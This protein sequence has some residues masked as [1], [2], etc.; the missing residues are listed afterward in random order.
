MLV[1]TGMREVPAAHAATTLHGAWQ[2]PAA[3]IL[4][5]PKFHDEALR[6]TSMERLQRAT[7]ARAYALPGRSGPVQIAGIVLSRVADV[8]RK[9]TADIARELLHDRKTF[10]GI[11]RTVFRVPLSLCPSDR[12]DAGLKRP[13]FCPDRIVIGKF[14]LF[15]RHAWIYGSRR[16]NFSGLTRERPARIQGDTRNRSRC[17]ASLIQSGG[18][19]FGPV[20]TPAAGRRRPAVRARPT[21][22]IAR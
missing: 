17:L 2:F 1:F 10:G 12:A 20:G 14:G 7:P 6:R 22:R 5:R 21:T 16:T 18:R 11:R 3:R 9:H 19:T 8:E 15:M 4:A 13:R